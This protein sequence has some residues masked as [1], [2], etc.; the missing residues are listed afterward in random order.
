MCKFGCAL[1]C[2]SCD[3][4]CM[5]MQYCTMIVSGVDWT[6]RELNKKVVP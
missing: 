5:P 6:S 4:V 3:T 1:S 2:M